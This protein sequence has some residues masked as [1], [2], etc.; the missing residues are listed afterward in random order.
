MLK[1]IRIN[2]LSKSYGKDK[3]LNNIT[4]NIDKGMFGLLGENG[5]G[6]STLMKILATIITHDT[7]DVKVCGYN[8]SDTKNLRNIIGY[9]PQE[10]SFYNNITVYEV[11]EYL[12]IL[13]GL[14]KNLRKERIN[15]VIEKTNLHRAQSKKVK[16][17]SGGMLRRLGIAQAV[18]NDPEI[19]IIDEPT[20]GLD[21]AERSNIR[22]LL[23]ELA[24]NKIVIISTHIIEDIESTCENLAVLKEGE[25]L[26][27]GSM[28]DMLNIVNDRVY[29]QDIN[30]NQVK[31]ILLK[32]YMVKSKQKKDG[33]EIRYVL[34][35]H[36]VEKN[37]K[38]IKCQSNLEDSFI[39]LT[40]KDEKNV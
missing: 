33:L 13:S 29:C 31:D 14:S 21:P 12:A 6:K 23:V 39:Y 1:Q 27:S 25:I 32:G 40:K 8:I 22:N 30:K 19:L 24:C 16:E 35:E 9:L 17:L 18:L 28:E 34:K 36:E 2:N 11:L 5:A 15:E 26:Y 7:G 3:V 20:V 10:F 38:A 4:V 37:K